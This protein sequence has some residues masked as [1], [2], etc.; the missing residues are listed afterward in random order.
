MPKAM[1]ATSLALGV[2]KSLGA[3]Y[4]SMAYEVFFHGIRWSLAETVI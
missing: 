1:E 2:I 3:A 4:A